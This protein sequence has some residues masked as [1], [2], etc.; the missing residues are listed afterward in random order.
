MSMKKPQ[1]KGLELARKHLASC[2]S[3]LTHIIKSQ[4]FLRALSYG[5]HQDDIH[6]STT[7][8]GCRPI[9]FDAGLNNRFSAPT[10]PRAT[11]IL[12]WKEVR[13]WNTL[14]ILLIHSIDW[15]CSIPTCYMCCFDTN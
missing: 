3:E 14:G 13:F 2:L 15:K 12:S 10:P 1:G 5:L 4:E 8:S 9:G 7:A 6:S 11:H